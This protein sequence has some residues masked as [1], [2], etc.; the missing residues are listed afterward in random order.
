VG[1]SPFRPSYC[2]CLIYKCGVLYKYEVGVLALHFPLISNM[3]FDGQ[4]CKEN[5]Q[6]NYKIAFKNM[7]YR[8]IGTTKFVDFPTTS[9]N[10]RAHQ[11]FFIAVICVLNCIYYQSLI[12]PSALVLPRRIA[13]RIVYMPAAGCCYRCSVVC[14][15]VCCP[16]PCAL[17]KRLNRSR[18]RLGRELVM[19]Q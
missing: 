14:L 4:S 16:R 19:I 2:Q 18:C 6:N 15:C 9:G 13:I 10:S 7:P 5:V 8:A 1:C 3:F 11:Y 12:I 17:L